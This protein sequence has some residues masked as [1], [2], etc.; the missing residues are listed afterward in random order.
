VTEFETA[1]LAILERI[2]AALERR[3][4]PAAAPAAAAGRP[5][6]FPPAGPR[7]AAGKPA[8]PSASQGPQVASD[9]DLDGKYGN[10]EIKKDPPRWRGDPMAPCVMSDC[11]ADYLLCLADFYDWRAEQAEKEGKMT[12]TGK[13]QAEF[14]R[15]DA[16]RARG[17]A[18][19]NGTMTG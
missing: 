10:P 3:T 1:A 8:G 6:G 18:K 9:N 5:R 15:M 11:P 12:S 13:P 19:R 2:A 14:I 7:Q 4:A 17:W 16:A